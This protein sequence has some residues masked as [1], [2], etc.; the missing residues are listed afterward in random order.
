M[1][2]KG[3]GGARARC[4]ERLRPV[5]GKAGGRGRVDSA[6]GLPG[7][8][9]AGVAGLCRRMRHSSGEWS[10]A[11]PGWSGSAGMA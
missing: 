3:A 2:L 11:S 1:G 7:G 8:V 6:G 10:D 9:V 5:E 4:S